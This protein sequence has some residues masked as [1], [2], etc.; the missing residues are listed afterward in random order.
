MKVIDLTQVI[1]EGMPVYP[2]TEPPVLLQG[3]TLEKDGFKEKMITMFSHTGTH[4]DAPAHLLEGGRTLDSF[5]LDHFQGRAVLYSHDSRLPEIGARDLLA[6]KDRI[7]KADY[8]LIRSS[9]DRYWGEESYFAGYPVLTPDAADLLA[10]WGL[11]GIGLDMISID[12]AD[13]HDLPVHRILL[14]KNICII[15]NLKGLDRLPADRDFGFICF[16]LKIQ[17]ADGSPV[18]AAAFLD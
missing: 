5:A 6:L 17:D 11:K 1:C 15:E 9:W 2:G 4:I 16:P 14:E 3:C 18:R 12:P 7:L 8:L 10:D 13:A